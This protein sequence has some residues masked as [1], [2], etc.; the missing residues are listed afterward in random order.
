[1]IIVAAP[2]DAGAGRLARMADAV[3]PAVLTR[4]AT[5][6]GSFAALLA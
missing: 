1:M 5:V 3:Y 2:A 4:A 6:S